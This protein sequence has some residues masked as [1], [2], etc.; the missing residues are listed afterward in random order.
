MK[1][2]LKK[3]LLVTSIFFTGFFLTSKHSGAATRINVAED[4]EFAVDGTDTA[5]DYTNLQKILNRIQG[6]KKE[7]IIYIPAGDYYLPQSLRVYSYTHLILAEH[8][9]LHRLDEGINKNL[10]HNVDQNGKMDQ[11]GGYKMSHDITIE[12]G[13]WDGG[14]ISKATEATDL[15]R[16]DHATNITVKNCRFKNVYDCHH[17][18]FI[19]VKNGLVQNCTF[20]NFY[21]KKGGENDYTLAREAF[22]L[23]TAW[24]D[25]MSDPTKAWARNTVLDGTSCQ[26]ITVT[27]C[28]FDNIP[29][30]VGQH[31]FTASGKYKNK[32][33]EIS[34]NTFTYHSSKK[35]G[36]IAI[37]GIG[38]D[39]VKIFGNTINGEYMF[40]IHII[41]TNGIVIRSNKIQ[42]MRK[43][44][45]MVDGGKNI[46]LHNN[47]IKKVAE[48]GISCSNG[49]FKKIT[50][51]TITNS[52]QNGICF[53]GG[54]SVK[55]LSEN[56]IKQA[57]KSG[58]SLLGGTIGTKK[59]NGIIK[60][61]INGCGLNGI[62]VSRNCKISSI[63]G[64]KISNIKN[65]GISLTG[66]AKVTWILKNTIKKCGK[67]DI[68]NG[69][70]SKV[71]IKNN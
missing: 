47:T 52:G 30:G 71:I 57:K 59:T 32:D 23:E 20:K 69:L 11:T 60:N 16:F 27:G 46:T 61:T 55:I 67:H 44:G 50:K 24:T 70:K 64:N 4:E 5:E 14:N 3:L 2:P 31:H 10:L 41:A 13:L 36:K 37:T 51:N 53:Y 42:G 35:N 28:T 54:S 49:S 25:N 62:T 21:Y 9:T 45:I 63:S 8:A 1:Y 22:Q 68:W 56:T 19:G 43:N 66:N 58:F 34:N 12:G 40:S 15:V 48:Q 39:N 26:S 29:C 33:I 18:E 7:V 17:L 6:A 65:N 38:M